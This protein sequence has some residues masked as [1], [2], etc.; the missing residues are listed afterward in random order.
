M[1]EVI[2]HHLA[3]ELFNCYFQPRYLNC[4]L[5][6]NIQNLNYHL[7]KE[8]TVKTLAVGC[9]GFIGAKCPSYQNLK[10]WQTMR[11]LP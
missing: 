5:E 8:P 9:G 6:L 4:N 7:K 11:W 2:L 1:S 3:F 10:R